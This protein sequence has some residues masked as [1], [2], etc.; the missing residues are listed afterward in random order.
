MPQTTQLA[1][2]DAS[3]VLTKALLRASERLGLSQAALARTIGVSEAT[4]SRVARGRSTVD[5]AT[6]EGELALLLLR[7]FRSLDALVGGDADAARAWMHAENDHL[8]GVPAARIQSVEGLAD[9]AIYLDA[10]R[11]RL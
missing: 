1:S 11:A 3:A 6:K 4:A 10:L 7:A 8:R 9:V 5:P 2:P